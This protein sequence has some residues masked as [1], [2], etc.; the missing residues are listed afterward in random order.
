MVLGLVG[1]GISGYTIVYLPSL[2][3]PV[4]VAAQSLST[5]SLPTSINVNLTASAQDV[6]QLADSLPN[7]IAVIVCL[8]DLTN[9]KNA[10][11]DLSSSLTNVKIQTG[12]QSLQS[13]LQ[14]S[15]EQL[16]QVKSFVVYVVSFLL[17]ASILFVLTGLGFF[18]VA[19]KI[20]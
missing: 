3:A 10:L 5:I 15:G 13:Q 4:D 1:S 2:L 7:C 9:A 12:L 17:G 8:V 18:L 14:A 11:Y 20:S 19:R 6:K 16:Y